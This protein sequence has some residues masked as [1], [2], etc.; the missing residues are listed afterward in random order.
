[1]GLVWLLLVEAEVEKEEGVSLEGLLD[2][3]RN[4]FGLMRGAKL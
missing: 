2:Q 3:T 1:M 4:E